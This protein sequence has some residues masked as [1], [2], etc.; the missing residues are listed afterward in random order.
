VQRTMLASLAVQTVVPLGITFA[1]PFVAFSVLAPL[2]SLGLAG[3]WGARH[4]TFPPR[5]R[6]DCEPDD[7]RTEATPDG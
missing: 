3:L 4:G 1:R 2:W 5:D 7:A 6:P